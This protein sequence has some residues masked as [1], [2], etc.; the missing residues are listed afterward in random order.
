MAVIPVLRTWVA[1][2][3]VTAAYMNVNIR[4]AGN[5]FL[6]RPLAILRQTVAQSVP[7]ATYTAVL[8]DTEDIDRDAGHSTSSNTG[9]YIPQTTGYQF[10][11]YTLPWAVNGTGARSARFRMNGA[12]TA[13]TAAGRTTIGNGGGAADTANGGS[14]FLYFNGTTD[15][16]ELIAY[17][18]CGSALLTEVDTSVSARLQ[19][20]WVSS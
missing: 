15:Y 13:A 7:N 11:A 17:Q 4:D 18:N 8:F 1:G 10:L 20:I 2:E 6:G 9:R 14:G 19:A 5:F 3:L 12:D 16:V